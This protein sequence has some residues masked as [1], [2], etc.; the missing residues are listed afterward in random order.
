MRYFWTYPFLLIILLDA[1]ADAQQCQ[2]PC[3][4]GTE[5]IMKPKEHG[6]SHTPVQS[7][8]RWHCDWDTADRICNFNRHYAEYSGY[9]ETTGFLSDAGTGGPI[10]FYDSNTGRPLFE[11]PK[12]RSWESFLEESSEHGWP[13]FRDGEVNWDYVRVLSNGEV[14][15]VDGTHLGEDDL[16]LS[17]T[18]LYYTTVY[19]LRFTHSWLFMT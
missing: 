13:S 8:L 2:P 15:S 6:T 14:V 5:D 17:S 12:G 1:F 19:V 11:A 9:W 18:V 7:N 4:P 3:V 10:V 16:K